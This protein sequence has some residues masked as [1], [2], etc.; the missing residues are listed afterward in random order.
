MGLIDLHDTSRF[1]ANAFSFVFQVKHYSQNNLKIRYF[2]N[3]LSETFYQ[4][5]QLII[6]LS[7]LLPL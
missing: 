4:Y 3:D 5:R 2:V 6:I 1:K 7:K